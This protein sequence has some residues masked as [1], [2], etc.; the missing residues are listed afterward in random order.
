MIKKTRTDYLKELM[1]ALVDLYNSM[2]TSRNGF[3]TAFNLT[4]PQLDIIQAVKSR[5]RTTSVLA[6]EFNVSPSAVSQ[7]VDQLIEKNLVERIEDTVDRR[8]TNIHLSEDGIKLFDA[9]YEKFLNHLETEYSAL[10][11]KELETLLTSIR[12]IT[13]DVTEE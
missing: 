6:K 10:S 13:I 9:I 2:A 4:R 8:I 12:K 11:V 5:P 3:L 7:M 1:P